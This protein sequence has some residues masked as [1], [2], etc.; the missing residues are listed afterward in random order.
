MNALIVTKAVKRLIGNYSEIL[1]LER[2]HTMSINKQPNQTHSNQ[3]D[4]PKF[5]Q[6]IYP[7]KTKEKLSE[8]TVCKQCGA[9]YNKGRWQW[10]EAPENANQTTCS[11]CQRINDNYPSGFVSLKG[12]F[13]TAH[14][15]EIQQLIQ[16][17]TERER[18]EHPY[19]R[20]IKIEHHEDIMLITTTDTHL[21]RGIGEAIK[22]A[23]QG[24]LSIDQV[25][26]ENLVRVNW[27]R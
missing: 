8:P 6:D 22:R 27:M 11:A 17:F 15:T 24:E 3:F 20:I 1:K 18:S 5:Q 7:Y 4:R 23:Y 19:K 9:V 14:N 26:G 2:K 16:N 12:Q 13:L 21:A 10:T 25:S